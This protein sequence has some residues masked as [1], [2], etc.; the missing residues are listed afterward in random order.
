ML[1]QLAGYGVD[2]ATAFKVLDRIQ[3]LAIIPVGSSVLYQPIVS[4][5]D[6]LGDMDVSVVDPYLSVADDQPAFR[7]VDNTLCRTAHELFDVLYS[8][9]SCSE[10]VNEFADYDAIYGPCEYWND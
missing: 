8:E 7:W 9:P 5:V 4:V 10:P 6:L 1:C 3:S 2:L